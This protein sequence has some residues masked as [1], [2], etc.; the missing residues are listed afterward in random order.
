MRRRALTLLSVAAIAG[1]V[2]WWLRHAEV[3]TA[4][5]PPAAAA[6][7]APLPADSVSLDDEARKQL[8]LATV[9]AEA[10]EAMAVIEAAGRV[11][12]PL[13]LADAFFARTAAQRA[14]LPANSE[15][16]RVRGL[17]RDRENASDREL[18]AAEA[19]VQKAALD[20]AVAEAHL[21]ASWGVALAERAD[22]DALVG[23][24]VAGR[25]GLA[26]IEAFAATP[27]EAIPN[28]LELTTASPERR[29]LAAHL[30]GPAPTIDPLLQGR[31]WL[32]LID[33][34]SPPP[35]TAL[36][37]QLPLASQTATGVWVPDS[38]I[39]RA[40]GSALVFVETRRNS[41]ERRRVA[42]L[43]AGPAGRLV[44]GR[45]EVGNA[46]VTR[47]AQQLLAVARTTD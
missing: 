20:A 31:A 23:E 44:S 6:P 43:G 40:G 45:V 26:R 35:G 18:E 30:L 46:V 21:R 22:L 28:A 7:L 11:L 9:P 24:L 13:P 38:A 47:G 12:D 17:H 4:P 39:V 2:I 41:F 14:L 16:A 34:D 19:A 37:A 10:G 42:L 29:I 33:R 3:T 1:G 36:R 32:V 5:E 15:R 8:D 25:M 27:D